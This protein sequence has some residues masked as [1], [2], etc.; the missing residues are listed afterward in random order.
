M[1]MSDW[2]SDVCSSDLAFGNRDVVV[3]CKI[4]CAICQR[5]RANRGGRAR[6]VARLNPI[7]EA[8]RVGF[9]AAA[10]KEAAALHPSQFASDMGIEKIY[11]DGCRRVGD[12]AGD[13]KSTRLNSSH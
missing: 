13:R 11:R 7:C 4:P 1:R 3:A 12:L 9:V 2:S 10:F 8:E 5:D 6:Q